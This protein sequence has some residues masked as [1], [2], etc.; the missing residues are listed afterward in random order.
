M[1]LGTA[2]KGTRDRTPGQTDRPDVPGYRL[3][4]R[5]SGDGRGGVDVWKAEGPG[6]FLAALRVIRLRPDVTADDLLGLDLL[7]RA[8]HPNLLS[9]FG[10][11]RTDQTLILATELPDH[12][13]WDRFLQAREAGETGL[14]R[15]ELL[16]HLVDAARGIDY[17]N[18]LSSSDRPGSSL[19]QPH[20]EI[21]PR[22]IF[23]VG[24]GIKVA[25]IDPAQVVGL[26]SARPS[27][28]LD[29]AAPER[30]QS[31]TSR[32][33][34]QYSLALTYCHLR[35]GRLPV[36]VVALANDLT[37]RRA[38]LDSLPEVERSA[39]VRALDPDPDHRWPTC[40]AFLQALRADILAASLSRSKLDDF[41]NVDDVLNDDFV[42][43]AV[44]EKENEEDDPVD[45]SV[46]PPPRNRSRALT[47]S[48]AVV[49]TAATLTATLLL[50][51]PGRLDANRRGRRIAAAPGKKNLVFAQTSAPR[52]RLQ[53]ASTDP[54]G[55]IPT[56]ATV[57]TSPTPPIVESPRPTPPAPVSVAAPEIVSP[58]AP[59]DE[60]APTTSLP[61]LDP[62][63]ATPAPP[64]ESTPT[65]T[66]D[67]NP[68]SP[69]LVGVSAGGVSI[70]SW[71]HRTA[72][73]V[74]AA[75]PVADPAPALNIK[76]PVIRLTAPETL[77]V[78]AGRTASLPV[79]FTCDGVYG[80]VEL[81]LKG[82]P[83]GVSALPRALA[84]GEDSTETSNPVTEKS[85]VVQIRATANCP[86]GE[87]LARLI[88]TA[89]SA[90]A[91]T[92][93][94][95]SV[96]P[97]PA[98]AS[99][100]RGDAL[101]RHD[102]F[103]AALAAYSE[104]ITIDPTD[105]LAFHGRGLAA[106]G[107]GDL[108]AAQQDIM[109]ALRLKPE[110]PTALNNLGLIKLARGE[111]AAAIVD[112]DEAI[113]LDPSYAVVRYNRGRAYS[114]SNATEKALADFDEAIRL[115]PKFAKAFKARADVHAHR[116]RRDLA[117]TDYDEAVRLRPDD[118]A[119][120][121]NRGLLLFSMGDHH[122]A[123][124]D[125]DEAIRTNPRYA[126]VRYN[127]GRVYAYLGDT[128]EAL[129]SFD[130]ALKLDPNLSR[131]SQA[132]AA[133]LNRRDPAKAATPPVHSS[134]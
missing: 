48:V 58:T 31:Q 126:V 14:P 15:D 120:L 13:L 108:D 70:L 97:S 16:E 131:A 55:E 66:A 101:L 112:F 17:L 32:Q 39:I 54:R 88:A 47:I 79:T 56:P 19:G 8:R 59:R 122:R 27:W 6:G 26:A 84:S 125:F 100:R 77:T 110:T 64:V 36:S 30:F 104:S 74:V 87:T 28:N 107:K 46:I 22:T 116:G 119:A 38:N 75:L 76:A 123:I 93:V 53:D 51:S 85:R 132:R 127:R 72:P 63:T 134:Q 118:P 33:S 35:L 52:F 82:L 42:E 21:S 12:S 10:S 111:H 103:A 18:S 45:W 61:P 130:R 37:P 80:L 81:R 106:Y 71:L 94:R 78:E 34:D 90:R 49:M 115:D 4:E 109:T 121:N 91:E 124:A 41:Q 7:R 113:H 114:E 2:Y 95:V 129:S 5:L 23:F 3:L 65:P 24:G 20:G 9:A 86:E 44:V 29:Y 128:V 43:E 83:D 117:L 98:L 68:A 99:R 105:P 73:D 92:T 62:P 40:S 11:W 96:R 89:G 60:P 102:D 25:D 1:K 69:A 57:P 67:S 50:A 133:I